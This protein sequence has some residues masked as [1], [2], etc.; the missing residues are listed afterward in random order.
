MRRSP[1]RCGRIRGGSDKLH[2]NA[3]KR[4]GH[5]N[6]QAIFGA[7]EVEDD[8]IVTQEIHGAAELTLDLRW[9]RPMRSDCNREPGSDGTLGM[10]MTR[11]ELFE[12]PPGDHL[13]GATYHV[14]KLVTTCSTATSSAPAL[15]PS[16]ASRRPPRRLRGQAHREGR[17]TRRV[18]DRFDALRHTGELQRDHPPASGDRDAARPGPRRSRLRVERRERE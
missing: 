14:T 8:P 16:A 6:H 4:I 12:R 10:R 18:L 7:P 15:T 17:G 3:T 13:H 1:D 9:I 5:V 2:Q 11:P